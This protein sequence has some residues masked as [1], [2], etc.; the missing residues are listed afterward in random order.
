MYL[1][2]TESSHHDTEAEFPEP[3]QHVDVDPANPRPPADVVQ[4]DDSDDPRVT[5]KF[6]YA[7]CIHLSTILCAYGQ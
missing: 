2:W 1:I 5:P 7:L 3:V 4:H 6:G